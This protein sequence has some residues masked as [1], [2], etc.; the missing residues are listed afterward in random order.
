MET[1]SS[2]DVSESVPSRDWAEL[3]DLGEV[4][5]PLTGSGDSSNDGKRPVSSQTA[6]S[7]VPD[8]YRST[9]QKSK[10]W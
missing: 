10:Y 7:T 6:G 2:A 3:V 9:T 5:G 4:A 8:T 1:T